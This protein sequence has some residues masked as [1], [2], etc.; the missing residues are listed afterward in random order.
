MRKE[1][2]AGGRSGRI[3]Q[4]P[5]GHLNATLL[6]SIREIGSFT[7]WLQERE[8]IVVGGGGERKDVLR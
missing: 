5:L 3:S 2:E 1:G 6:V 4:A 8:R 7:F